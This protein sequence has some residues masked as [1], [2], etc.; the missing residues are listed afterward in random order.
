[1]TLFHPVSDSGEVGM[2]YFN[3][4]LLLQINFRAHQVSLPRCH[5]GHD[6]A[7]CCVNHGEGEDLRNGKNRS[8]YILDLEKLISK[9]NMT[10][11]STQRRRRFLL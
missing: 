2:G 11:P 9:V 1:M 8:G 4:F 3:L 6:D 10:S 7:F 5:V